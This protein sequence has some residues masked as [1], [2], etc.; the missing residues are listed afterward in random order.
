[1]ICGFPS[2]NLN[3]H[4]PQVLLKS[5][6]AASSLGYT[7]DRASSITLDVREMLVGGRGG[8][9]RSDRGRSS[10]G[11]GGGGYGGERKGYGGGGG[12]YG[13]S[14][15]GSS[16]DASSGRGGGDWGKQSGARQYSGAGG[17]RGDYGSSSAPSSRGGRTSRG[18]TGGDGGN[19][20]DA[21]AGGDKYFEPSPKKFSSGSSS[22][23]APK[24]S[25]ADD[26]GQW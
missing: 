22:R 7:V 20:Y 25:I 1:M 10:W 23:G 2:D 17:G 6:E 26:W 11:R 19:F 21:G 18:G 16:R 3:Y 4:F 8:P 13:G 5:T 24:K 12:G 15:G 14:R 9:P